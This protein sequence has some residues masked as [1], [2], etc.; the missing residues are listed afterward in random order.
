MFA[1]ECL[2]AF[3][4]LTFLYLPLPSFTFRAVSRKQLFSDAL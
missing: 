3:D 2:W 4:G 1:L